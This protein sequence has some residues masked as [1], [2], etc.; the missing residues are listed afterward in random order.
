MSVFAPSEA[1]WARTDA[2]TP[3]PTVTIV[4]TAATPMTI[5]RTVR[6]DR[7]RWG[8]FRGARGGAWLPACPQTRMNIIAVEKGH[9]FARCARLLSRVPSLAPESKD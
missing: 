7:R 3:L 6:I 8:V 5:P 9:Y 1:I 2:V 4:T